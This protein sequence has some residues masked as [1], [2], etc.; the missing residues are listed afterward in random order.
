VICY[1]TKKL[2][3]DLRSIGYVLNPYDPCVANKMINGQQMTICWHVD[4]LFLGHKDHKVVSDTISWLQNQY[5]TPDKP[6]KA[7]RSPTHDYLGMNIDFSTPGNIS[8]DMIPY[9]K[10]VIT[11][12]PEMITGV[13]S[14]PA[15]DHI[16]KIH[17]PTEAHILPQS[18][19]IA[20][21][22]TTA[23]LL[24]LSWVCCNIQTAVAFLTT[25]VKVPDEDDWD[26]LKHVLKYLNDT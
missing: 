16:F 3:T 6:L 22:H 21:H 9:L 11:E 26:K 13:A 8:Y 20:Y 15:A 24:F 1:F 7:T 10:K 12:F 23:Q 4:D 5:E 18:Q 25:R 19:A 14:T 17:P 2:V